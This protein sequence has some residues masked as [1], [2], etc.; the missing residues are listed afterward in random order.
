MNNYDYDVV[1]V[2][3]GVSGLRVALELESTSLNCLVLEKDHKVGGR[4]RSFERDGFTMDRGFQV[5]LTAYPE[6]R[7]CLDLDRLGLESFMSGAYT[8]T[9]QELR[10]LIDPL[11]HPVSGVNTVLSG[12][13][14]LVDKWKV[15]R[16]RCSLKKQS[17][18]SL[19]Q[20]GETTTD[21]F[22][23]SYGFSKEMVEQFFRPFFAG[24]FL[25]D[26]LETSSS[27]FKFVYKMF[28]EGQA[29]L[30]AGG[31][32][33]I[34]EQMVSRLSNTTVRTGR[35]IDSID[36][37][38]VRVDNSETIS[39]RAIVDATCSPELIGQ[40]VERT[41]SDWNGTN[42]YYFKVKE[43]PREEPILYLNAGSGFVNNLCF[44]SL[45]NPDYAPDDWHLLSVSTLQDE[46]ETVGTIR[47][48]LVDW[49]GPRAE[50][51]SLIGRYEVDRALPAYTPDHSLNQPDSFRV[52]DGMYRTGDVLTTPSLNGAMKS[53]RR[54][55]KQIT[56]DLTDLSS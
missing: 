22:L 37:S 50:D 52:D 36:G 9:A 54:V 16:L 21:E 6:V 18:K 56:E 33:A 45:V 13:G 11:S 35:V 15:F 25:E 20:G 40:S 14:S 39:A 44:P 24:V 53:G 27:M 55:G 19:F 41:K 28:A 2:G 38:D 12:P 47:E 49:F 29:A 31:I 4:V 3:A 46:R 7:S 8:R 26:R 17:V 42:C 51:W 32:Q 30:P 48:E 10:T 5:L 1:I 23:R 34:P 43:P